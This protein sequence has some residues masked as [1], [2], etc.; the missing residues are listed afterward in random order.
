MKEFHK[1]MVETGMTIPET[2]ELIGVHPNSVYGWLRLE[3]IMSGE[4][5]LK[6]IVNLFDGAYWSEYEKR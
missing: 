6:I 2:A 5:A 3:H 1:K 4:D